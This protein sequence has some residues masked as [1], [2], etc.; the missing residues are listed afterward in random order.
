MQQRPQHDRGWIADHRHILQR[1]RLQQDVLMYLT[2]GIGNT[3]E[4]YAID[5]AGNRSARATMTI[6]LRAP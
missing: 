4:A 6:D 2:L 1:L 3:I 5:E